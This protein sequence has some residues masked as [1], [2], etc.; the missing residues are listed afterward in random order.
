MAERF[1]TP[2]LKTTKVPRRESLT[3]E[4]IR[5]EA[6]EKVPKR[7]C[8]CQY[9][10]NTNSTEITQSGRAMVVRDSSVASVSVA[11]SLRG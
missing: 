7:T 11:E 3:Y 1:K 10:V 5:T 9:A 4:M 2:V 8:I 6:G